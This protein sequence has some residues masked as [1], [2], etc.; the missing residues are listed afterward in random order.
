MIAVK[1]TLESIGAEGVYEPPLLAE[2]GQYAEVTQ[3]EWGDWPDFP[4]GYWL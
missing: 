1:E 3:G 4:V 2:V